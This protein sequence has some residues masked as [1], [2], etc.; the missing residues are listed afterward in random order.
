MEDFNAN[1]GT[2]T[3]IQENKPTVTKAWRKLMEVAKNM[4]KTDRL[5][6]LLLFIYF[7]ASIH[8]IITFIYYL[9]LL[10]L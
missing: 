8:I 5:L 7:I 1:V 3:Y 4:K 9:L 10:L 6:L 2:C